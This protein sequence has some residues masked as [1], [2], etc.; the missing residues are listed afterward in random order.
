MV[1]KHCY[2]HRVQ[3]LVDISK[4]LQAIV[5]LKVT[6]SSTVEKAGCELGLKVDRDD[7]GGIFSTCSFFVRG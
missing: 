7:E 5:K 1:L 2:S 4:I 3:L 6:R